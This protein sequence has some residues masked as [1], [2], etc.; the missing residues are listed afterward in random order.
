MQTWGVSRA[1]IGLSVVSCSL[2]L[3]SSEASAEPVRAGGVVSDLGVRMQ[4]RDLGVPQVKRGASMRFDM[5]NGKR[6]W[7]TALPDGQMIVT[8][9]YGHGKVFVGGGFHSRQ[10]YAVDAR[11]GRIEWTVSAPDGGPSAAIVERDRLIFNTESCTIFVVDIGTGELVWS[12]YLGDPMMAQ[13]AAANGRVFTAHRATSLQGGHAITA[14]SLADGTQLWQVELR[15]DLISA[16]ALAGELI[17]FAT[18]DGVVHARRQDS[19]RRVWEART[20]A[21]SAP[22]IDG[23]RIFIV[24]RVATPPG[25]NG[26]HEQQVVLDTRSGQLIREL[27]PVPAGHLAGQGRARDLLQKQRGGWGNVP[28]GSGHLGLRNVAEGWAYQGARPTVIDGRAYMVVGDRI[29]CHNAETGRLLWSRRYGQD[30]GALSVSPP[31]VVGSQLVFGTVDGHVYGLDIDTGLTVWA[32]DVGEPVVFQPSI[33]HGWVYIGTA[34]G[35]L[36]AFPVGDETL[37]GWHMWGGDPAHGGPLAATA[38]PANEE[39][40]EAAEDELGQGSLRVVVP[41]RNRIEDLP[42]ERT[43]M[44]ADVSGFVASVTVLQ[45]FANPHE[46]PLEAA[47]HFPLPTNAAVDAMELRIGE[48]TITGTIRERQEARIV[49]RRAREA[50]QIAGLLEQQRPNLFT[51]R[52]ANIP[53][54]QSI[55]VELHYVQALPYEDGRYEFSFPMVAGTRAQDPTARSGEDEEL[56]QH[57]PGMRPASEIGVTIR[58]DA[59]VPIADITS[60]S[61]RL[62]IDRDGESHAEI[63]LAAGDRVPNRDLVVR[64]VVAGQQPRSALLAHHDERGGFFTLMVQPARHSADRFRVE[65][66]VTLAL[67]TSS[68]MHGGPMGQAKAVANRVLG[69]LDERDSLQIIGFS[70]EV[71]RFAPAPI[72]ATQAEVVRATEHVDGLRALGTTAMTAGLQAVL[73]Q[74]PTSA[75]VLDIV[76]LVTDGYIASEADLMRLVNERLGNRRIFVVGVGPAPNR[77]LLERLA[78]VG[79]GAL[80]VVSPGDDPAG[81]ATDFLARIDRPQL[82]DVEV[83]WGGLAVEGLRPERLPDLYAGQPLLVHGRYTRPGRGQVVLRGRIA[84]RPWSETLQVELGEETEGN[85]AIAPIWA[86]AS[87]RELMNRLYL[88]DDESTQ[89]EITNLGL[90]FGLVTRFTSFVAVEEVVAS[91]NEVPD[92]P[93]DAEATEPEAEIAARADSSTTEYDFDDDQI[94]GELLAGNYAIAQEVQVDPGGYGDSPSEPEYR[95]GRGPRGCHCRATQISDRS[96]AAL[97]WGSL[98]TLLLFRRARSRRK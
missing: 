35:N 80:L 55:E 30:Q 53:P 71:R 26:P 88:R 81:V 97:L 63:G 54:G 28:G 38:L 2:W 89:R 73:G 36:I 64:Y 32:Y 66:R 6:G 68:S 59:G 14:L 90:R 45:V 4:V 24:R 7:V 49:Y 43:E 10:V 87:I 13:P 76:V 62:D 8:P 72:D 77:F 94:E 61:H 57:T 12:Q 18:M 34:Q 3:W 58:L 33:A 17:F 19:G 78:E 9:A 27:P 1:F 60:P 96:V 29:Q 56:E 5:H 22:W 47:Y 11:T 21:T 31:A 69:S 20:G 79:R 82:T 91:D 15:A 84:G 74:P 52:V 83:E 75:E 16:P 92:T 85:D 95:L 40:G 39:G 67:D 65:R 37:D 42:L 48:R 25:R 50:G 46:Q 93:R 41:G 86:R 98:L 51:Q 44:E 70:D 23:E